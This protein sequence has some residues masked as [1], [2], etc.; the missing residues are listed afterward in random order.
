VITRG[1][2]MR[3]A[4]ER[5]IARGRAPALLGVLDLTMEYAGEKCR[6]LKPV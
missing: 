3:T 4:F 5:V 1:Y 6:V 2:Y